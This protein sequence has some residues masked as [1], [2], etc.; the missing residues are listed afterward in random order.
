MSKLT[1]GEIE[2][3]DYLEQVKA[4]LSHLSSEEVEE[5]ISSLQAHIDIALGEY[6]NGAADLAAVK[7][8]L[9]ELDPPASYADARFVPIGG[10]SAE[11]SISK[12]AVI[13]A[14]LLPFGIILAI[15][16]MTVSS[17]S[18]TA[19]VDGVAVVE[20]GRTFW[21]WLAS[22]TL[23]PLGIISPFAATILGLIGI[24]RIRAS[25]GQITGLPL[26]LFVTL[27]YPIL[28]LDGILFM[29]SVSLFQDASYW[30][31]ALV[32]TVVLILAADYF[33]IRKGWKT[34]ASLV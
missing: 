18:S 25:L 8:V 11:A 3:S 22:F 10:S 24:S 12:H 2:I 23:I 5:I 20:Q 6:P 27:F 28:I 33:T 7:A 16:M 1:G 19:Y 29:T 14:V 30:N 26:A 13:G 9:A 17:S 15:S 34:A 31:I 32:I 4:N 21:Q